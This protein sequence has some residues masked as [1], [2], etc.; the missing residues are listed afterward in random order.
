MKKTKI[1]FALASILLVGSV[2]FAD[3]RADIQMCQA[4]Y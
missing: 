4:R 1:S 2:S 3:E